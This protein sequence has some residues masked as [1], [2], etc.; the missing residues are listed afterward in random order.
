[1]SFT[2]Y[3]SGE[4]DDEDDMTYLLPEDWHSYE[5]AVVPKKINSEIVIPKEFNFRY[6]EEK[7]DKYLKNSREWWDWE[8]L[9]NYSYSTLMFLRSTFQ[10]FV[11]K[12]NIDLSG[13]RI[14]AFLL[15]EV[16]PNISKH[17]ELQV[18]REAS[19]TQQ[20]NDRRSFIANKVNRHKV[21][22]HLRNKAML[23]WGYYYA[24]KGYYPVR[25][26]MRLHEFNENIDTRTD[27]DVLKNYALCERTRYQLLKLDKKISSPA[28]EYYDKGA[29]S[30]QLY[31]DVNM[32]DLYNNVMSSFG[33]AGSE[34]IEQTISTIK[35]RLDKMSNENDLYKRVIGFYS[36]FVTMRRLLWRM[37]CI[38]NNFEQ[39]NRS[40]FAYE[41]IAN[42]VF[43]E[44]EVVDL[45]E[46]S[47]AYYKSCDSLL[48][49]A[50]NLDPRLLHD[51]QDVTDRF[52]TVIT[53]ANK[54]Y[55]A[56]HL[57]DV[58]LQQEATQHNTDNED[59]T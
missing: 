39:G 13:Q 12:Y 41:D 1:M 37:K 20:Y 59:Y 2:Y 5:G 48:E 33:Y 51:I 54:Y 57:L 49:D 35:P 50:N 27:D 7:R 42:E 32:L 38:N 19:L 44:G 16:D 9:K 14:P 56:S 45:Y 55:R 47:C 58:Q 29:R 6:Y 21:I 36:H 4:R 11:N 24:C 43:A 23:A 10:S 8:K 30:S 53:I 46:R 25:D 3:S 31:P 22:E 26:V 17:I 28:M 15:K 34:T 52:A 18:K 40:T